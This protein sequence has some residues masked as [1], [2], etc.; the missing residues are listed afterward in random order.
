MVERPDISCRRDRS[1]PEVV[2]MCLL[3]MDQALEIDIFNRKA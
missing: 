3:N 2:S 1:Y